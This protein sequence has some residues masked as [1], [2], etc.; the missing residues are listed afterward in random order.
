[1]SQASVTKPWKG[2]ERKSVLIK[3][4]S[5]QPMYLAFLV[6]LVYSLIMSPSWLVGL[7]LTIIILA[8]VK[9]YDLKTLA[10]T[11]L[12]VSLF[13]AY[14]TVV[15]IKQESMERQLPSQVQTLR[16]LPDSLSI[17]GDLLSVRASEG[18]QV[19]QVYYQLQT[20]SEKK[21]FQNLD[22]LVSLSV[23]GTVERPIGQRNFNG[24]DY[25][26]Y[27]KREGIYGLVSV[28][29]IKAIR[30]VKP[31]HLVERV[32][33]WRRRLLVHIDHHFPAPMKHYMTGLLLGHLDQSFDEM[34][35]I[36]TEL[37]IIHLFA[38]SGMQVGFF[39]GIFRWLFLRVGL[40]R[41]YLK[42]ALMGFA[43]VYA[44]LTGFTISVVR[45]LIQAILSQF[46]LRQWDNLGLTILLLFF[47]S[48]HFLQ[49]PGGVLSF[50]YAFILATL[51]LEALQGRQKAVVESLALSVAILPLLMFY[52]GTFQ[53][54]SILLTAS[55]ALVFDVLM[56]P[57]L[58]LVLILSPLVSLAFLNPFFAFLEVLIK[59]VGEL[60]PRPLV[61]GSPSFLILL[62]MLMSLAAL[63]DFWTVKKV[64]YGLMLGLVVLFGVTKN[65]LENEVTIMD[66]G[67]GDSIFIR[68]MRGKNLLIDT[69]GRVVFAQKEQWRERQM[70]ANAKRTSIPYL[71][72]RGVSTIDQL[73]ITH[74]DTDHMGD[75]QVLAKAFKIKEIL[76]SPGAMT[77]PSFVE[78]LQ[79]MKTRVRLI[80]AGDQL[81]MMGSF[82]QVLYPWEQGDGGNNDSL[83][84]YGKLLDKTFLFTGDLEIEGE[85][86]LIN[87][88][89]K[90]AV[91][92][93]KAGH[94]GSKGSS[95]PA[96]LRHI[97]AK[98]ALISA[99]LNNRYHHP[100][101]E[102]LERFE[103]QGMQVYRT[104]QEGAI[105]FRGRRHWQ[106][107]TVR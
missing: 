106:I 38:L 59:W 1:M 40:F 33:L 81:P 23:V 56:L 14:F 18:K 62:I 65:P 25:K 41:E 7:G 90:L 58:G 15:K 2:S 67:Q 21:Y 11:L 89:P 16:L 22:H 4:L 6:A 70:T 39:I 77:E 97:N 17:D 49:T 13:A 103:Q 47:L 94:H 87:K 98:V 57:L 84:L 79:K 34:S 88:Y 36:Y 75:M 31:R 102:T 73:L 5:L 46:G 28:K 24:F 100:N 92:V 91:D 78:A 83:V 12:L 96:F 63:H 26:A 60:S 74:T 101:T 10:Q 53:P 51:D 93:L 8:L 54:L 27:L 66:I 82:L 95:D 104:D 71:K 35:E 37:G 72:S 107:E 68:D 52:F 43:L 105:R 44:G 64:R 30:P 85:K 76:V 32:R 69:G 45:S 9:Q 19:Y 80:K 61:F 29:S 86:A 50:A 20:P 42:Y 99:G 3:S 55:F 48:P